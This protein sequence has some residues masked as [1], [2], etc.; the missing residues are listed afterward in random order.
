MLEHKGQVAGLK[1]G[2]M[3]LLCH[4]PAHHTHLKNILAVVHADNV[5]SIATV[6]FD[7]AVVSDITRVE[8]DKSFLHVRT[9]L[10]QRD[11]LRQIRLAICEMRRQVA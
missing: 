7:P 10:S 4:H 11:K 6:P 8:S 5:S 9:R 3:M 2:P 1:L